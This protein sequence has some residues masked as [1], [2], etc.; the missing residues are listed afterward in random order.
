M[1]IRLPR[2]SR[3][4]AL[5][6]E[7]ETPS[8]FSTRSAP[9]I[10]RL[11]QNSRRRSLT[12]NASTTPLR[13]STRR[14]APS[15]SPRGIFRHFGSRSGCSTMARNSPIRTCGSGSPRMRPIHP[16]SWKRKSH[17]ELAGLNSCICLDAVGQVARE[18]RHSWLSGTISPQ[19]NR[20]GSPSQRLGVKSACPTP[21]THFMLCRRCLYRALGLWLFLLAAGGHWIGGGHD[22]IFR[23]KCNAPKIRRAGRE[24]NADLGF[25]A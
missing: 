7:R 11:F 8:A 5:S 13:G 18:D 6:L 19:R 23:R 4:C 20:T 2:T 25:A 9:R 14:K 17:S 24:V 15:V 12:E 10:G 3:H 16:C 1:P 21:A 22:P